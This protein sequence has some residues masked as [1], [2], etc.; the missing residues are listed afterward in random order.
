VLEFRILGGEG[1]FIG[2]MSSMLVVGE[3]MRASLVDA[4]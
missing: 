4:S 3:L 2:A 1:R